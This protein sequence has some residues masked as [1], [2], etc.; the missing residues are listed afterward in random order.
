MT[1]IRDTQLQYRRITMTDGSIYKY[2]NVWMSVTKK[3]HAV[4]T[5]L[6]DGIEYAVNN[7]N[8][9]CYNLMRK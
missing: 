1:S 9:F 8:G 6:S 2:R 7:S 4:K 5:G 3:N